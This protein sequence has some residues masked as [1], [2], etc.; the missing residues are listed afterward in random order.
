MINRRLKR[1][2]PLALVVGMTTAIGVALGWKLKS[3]PR[4]DDAGLSSDAQGHLQVVDDEG[5]TL[6]NGS[7]VPADVT[8]ERNHSSHHHLRKALRRGFRWLFS[9]WFFLLAAVLLTGAVG[10]LALPPTGSLPPPVL[11]PPGVGIWSTQPD[12]QLVAML[13]ATN[14][15]TDYGWMPLYLLT[16]PAQGELTLRIWGSAKSRDGNSSSS[17]SGIILRVNQSSKGVSWYTAVE[18][19]GTDPGELANQIEEATPRVPSVWVQFNANQVVLSGSRLQITMPK[20]YFGAYIPKGRLSPSG[21]W[22]PPP[23]GK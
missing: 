17:E 1:V 20:I 6:D 4:R 15:T 10:Y 19:P 18:T 16:N 14:M 13:D 11:T 3:L 12:T 9:L 7:N 2:A 5:L 22:Y 8:P 21:T 23:S